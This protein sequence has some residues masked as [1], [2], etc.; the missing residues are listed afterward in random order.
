VQTGDTTILSRSASGPTKKERILVFC[1]DRRVLGILTR[2]LAD[3]GHKPVSV[4]TPEDAWQKLLRYH[5]QLV[6]MSA[7]EPGLDELSLLQAVRAAEPTSHIPFLFLLRSGSILPSLPAEVNL[8][9]KDLWHAGPFSA[10]KLN[11]MVSELLTKPAVASAP[12]AKPEA[13]AVAAASE[14]GQDGAPKEALWDPDQTTTLSG[15]L[16]STSL[17]TLL[18]VAGQMQ[19]SGVIA[20]DDGSRVGNIY[21]VDGAPWHASLGETNG[22]NALFLL[23]HVKEGSFYFLS[24]APPQERTIMDNTTG[25]LLEGMRQLDEAKSARQRLREKWLKR[26]GVA[27]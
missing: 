13:G 5:I 27:S 11:Q 22:P 3:G 9:T 14:A 20:I 19:L 12:E 26:R 4:L 21:F 18:S 8:R 24:D 1:R 7:V 17:P 2:Y 16:S 10:E 6:V 25:L 15:N 23:F